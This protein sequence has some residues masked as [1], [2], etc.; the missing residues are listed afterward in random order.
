VLAA[1]AGLQIVPDERAYATALPTADGE[2]SALLIRPRARRVGGL[3]V[4][5]LAVVAVAGI[6]GAAAVVIGSRPA[7]GPSASAVPGAGVSTATATAKATAPAGA[8]TTGPS[9]P[10]PSAAVVTGTPGR[11]SE[12]PA[13]PARPSSGAPAAT[14]DTGPPASVT[15]R[16]L[17]SPGGSVQA[18]CTDAGLAQLHSWSAAKSYQVGRV[19]AGPARSTSAEF[20]HGNTVTLMTVTCTDG[21]PSASTTVS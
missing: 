20:R 15:P 6:I 9:R 8:T 4:R 3:A 21:V 19:D 1:A 5:V 14:P 16:T 2:P 18:T 13:T 10:P 12:T 7:G 17:S 11:P